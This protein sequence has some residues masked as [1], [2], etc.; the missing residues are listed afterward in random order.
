MSEN[1]M[2]GLP[3]EMAALLRDPTL[4]LPGRREAASALY[5]WSRRKSATA[6]VAESNQSS[7]LVDLYAFPRVGASSTQATES[8]TVSATY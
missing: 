3:H 1:L 4:D 8:P 7:M 5:A 6:S 2:K